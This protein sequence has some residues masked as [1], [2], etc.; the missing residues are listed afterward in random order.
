MAI[1]IRA[2]KKSFVG[3][4]ILDIPSLA[5]PDKGVFC[6][7]GPSGSGKTTL[8]RLI[9]GLETP[10]SGEILGTDG[11]KISFLFQEDR[12]IASLT[13]LQ[14]VALVCSKAKAMA[15][16]ESVNLASDCDKFPAEMSG[17]MCRRTAFARAVAFGGDILLLDEPFKGLDGDLRNTLVN[18]IQKIAESSLVILVSHDDSEIISNRTFH[19]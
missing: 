4:E 10:D 19:L 11:K 7:S 8:L 12:L 16:L 2:V 15:A 9:A 13:A 18:I 5:I 3:K 14:N 17:G 6:V 1:E